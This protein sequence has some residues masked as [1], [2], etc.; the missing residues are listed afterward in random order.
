MSDTETTSLTA[1]PCFLG[2]RPIYFLNGVMPRIQAQHIISRIDSSLYE[3]VIFPPLIYADKVVPL[4]P[5][6]QKFVVSMCHAE[7]V[8]YSCPYFIEGMEEI[9]QRHTV[10]DGCKHDK[11]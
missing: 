2:V 3:C 10:I 8:T 5:A 11:Q 7:F 9:L 6:F 1:S 4:Y